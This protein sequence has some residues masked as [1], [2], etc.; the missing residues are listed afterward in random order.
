MSFGIHQSDSS[1]HLVCMPSICKWLD[2]IIPCCV[3]CINAR[4]PACWML[5]IIDNRHKVRKM[6]CRV[7]WRLQSRV[8]KIGYH[9]RVVQGPTPGLC[10]L[11]P[12]PSD[13]YSHHLYDILTVQLSA[14]IGLLTQTL[15]AN[16]HQL[17]FCVLVYSM[18]DHDT[19]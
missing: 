3:Y 14:V 18:I 4:L 12:A 10:S 16:K 7:Q 5:D 9:Q 17:Y 8:K 1:H 11:S 15:A 2:Y 6:R 13:D 19:R